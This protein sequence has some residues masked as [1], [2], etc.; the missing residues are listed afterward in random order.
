MTFAT[1][2]AR[3]YSRLVNTLIGSGTTYGLASGYIC[4]GATYP[5]GM[6]Q[7]TPTYFEK[8][9]GFVANQ[10]SGGG[11]YNLGNFPM[12]P[13]KG[14]LTK[15]PNDI[16]SAHYTVSDEKGHAGYYQA[17]VNGDVLA[18]LT[19]AERSGMGRFTFPMLLEFE[20]FG[21]VLTILARGYLFREGSDGYDRIDD[22]ESLSTVPIEVKFGK[23]HTVYCALYAF[24]NNG[25]YCVKRAS[26][27]PIPGRSRRKERSRI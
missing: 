17:K 25:D 3:D 13:L 1:S 27:F 21:R 10:Y 15:S 18:E 16:R 26:V 2:T 7:F 14:E 5:H 20:G 23:D 8:N 24:V 9:S 11:C 19:V 12:F 22:Y 6:V 4:P